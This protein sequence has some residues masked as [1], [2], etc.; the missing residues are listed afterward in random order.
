MFNMSKYIPKKEHSQR[1]LIFCFHLKKTK[2]FK[3]LMVNMLHHKIRVNDGFSVLKVVTSRLQTKN[4]GNHQQNSK[5]WNCKA[6]LD[7]DDSQ[8][9]K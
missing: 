1:A 3:E 9:Q 5:L 2:H 7:E 4:L 6:L 8:K